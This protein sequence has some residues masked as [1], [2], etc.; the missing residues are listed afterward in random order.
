MN[1]SYNWLKDY[2]DFDLQPDEVAAALTSIGL[3]TGGVEEVQTI[4]GGLEGLVIGEVLT[5]EEHPNSD[6][7]HITTVNVGGAEPLQIVCG[8]PNVAAGQKVVVA[9]NGTKLYDGDECFTIKRSKIRGV[10]SNGMIC[11]EDEIGIGT[12]HAG[13]IVLPAD[14][15]VGTPAKEYYNVKSD[16]VLEVD[17]TPNRVDATSH[18][19]VARDLAAYLK[20][21]GKPANLKRPN[22]DA[23]KIDDETPAIE[24]VVENT[25]ACLRY[26]GITIKGV[27]VKESPEWLQN[28]LK[29]IGLRPIN[30]VV[31]VTNYILHGVGQPLH[32]FDADK[33]KG[34]KVVVRSAKEGS[35]F[36]TLDG[37]E[38]TLTD[39]DLMICNV[40]EPMCIAGV[41]GGLDSGVTE[42]TKNV[43]LES[44]TFHPTWIRK[45]ARRFGLNTD[46]SF[47][48][49]RGLDPNQTVDVMKRAALLIQEVAGGTIT[50]AIQD[51]YPAPVA[52]YRVELAYNK[53]NTLI[54]KVI[55]V[56]TVKSILESLE[57]K[58][59]SETAEGWVIDVPV[60]RIDV[61]R[62]VD[63]IEDI[64]R[65]YGYNNVEF[66]DNVKSNLSYQTPTD[67]S[68]KLQNLISEQLCGCGFNEILNNSLTRSAYYD[69]LSTY[70]VSHCVMLMNPL[71]ADLN[72][73]RQTLLF[74]GLESVEHNAKRKNGNIRFFEFGNCYDYNIDHKKEGETLAEFSEDYRLGLW[75][76]GSRVDNNWAH[77]N[78]KSSVYE[79]KAYVENILVRLGVN[80]Q[81]VIF[82]NLANDIYSAGLSI[83]T[84]S[85]RQLGTM[86]IV[87]P[88]ICKELDIETDVYYAELS[89]TLLMKE[90]KKSKVTFSEISKF[91]AVKRDL[92]LLLDKNVQFAEI[93][94]IATESER[95]LLKNIALF[96]VY[97]GKNLPAGKKSYAVSFYLQDEGKT[98]ND[99]QIDAIMKKIQTNLEQKLGAQLR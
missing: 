60:Y 55:P 58:I 1:I 63:V 8:A 77:P 98:L 21:N 10:E 9:V 51:I 29:V 26:S 91:P 3:E 92:A 67:R 64:L 66:S 31:D 37:V 99:K 70:P 24:V 52:P 45:T 96:D 65:I 87:S 69:N 20:Q 57:M 33:V 12:D 44:A 53:V 35:K 47:R 80:L 75:V 22:V 95:K 42:H 83:T 7:L 74:G 68:Y 81:K 86:G 76:S 93:E 79:L 89:W 38:R 71:S 25:E 61:Q 16:Y 17:I 40:E 54:G 18:F 34:N 4:K 15:V 78:E 27:T 48:Y 59:V 73:M 6:H 46:A 56:E 85:G 2:L 62:D 82:G 19:G 49:E 50:G 28:R 39:R 5:C 88:K 23:F 14:A 94:K 97:E 30:N 43:F 72:C 36:V 11:A 41:F 32:S 90:I 13:I 84:S